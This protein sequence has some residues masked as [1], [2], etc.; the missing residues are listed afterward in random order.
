MTAALKRWMIAAGL[1]LVVTELLL[2][3][4]GIS[5]MYCVCKVLTS[6]CCLCAGIVLF[7]NADGKRF[8]KLMLFAFVGCFLGDAV[9]GVNSVAPAEVFFLLGMLAFESAQVLFCCAFAKEGHGNWPDIVIPVAGLIFVLSLE[10]FCPTIELG[11]MVGFAAVYAG[12]VYT[13]AGKC[14]SL[15]LEHKREAW[16]KW[17]L[18]GAVLFALSDTELFLTLFHVPPLPNSEL[19]NHLLYFPALL[20]LLLGTYRYETVKK[21]VDAREKS[22]TIA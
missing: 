3:T 21:G 13:M 5:W 2:L 17:L 1:F 18:A 20:F 4:V 19:F 7:Q 22:H 9:L 11:E 8:P 15:F 16:T 6:A 12:T 14:A 10:Y